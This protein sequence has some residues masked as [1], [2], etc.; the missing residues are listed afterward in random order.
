MLLN[1]NFYINGPTAQKKHRINHCKGRKL[2]WLSV[3]RS[4]LYQLNYAM[5]ANNSIYKQQHCTFDTTF[6]QKNRFAE[7]KRMFLYKLEYNYKSILLF[8]HLHWGNG[9]GSSGL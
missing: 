7:M 1:V 2:F 3:T 9:A 8:P 4:A 6:N 5:L